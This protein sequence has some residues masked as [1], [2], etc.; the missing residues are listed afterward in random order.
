MS[1]LGNAVIAYILEAVKDHFF[2]ISVSPAVLVNSLC[3][4][5]NSCWVSVVATMSLEVLS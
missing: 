4:L 2:S 3:A 5:V 1:K